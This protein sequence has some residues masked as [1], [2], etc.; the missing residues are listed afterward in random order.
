MLPADNTV[1]MERHALGT[2]NYIRASIESAGALAVP[3]AAGIAMGMV[4]AA[5]ALLAA[6]PALGAHWFEI[7]LLAAVA[8]LALGG[9]LMARQAARKGQTLYRGPARKF[10]LCLC[11]AL[12]AGAALTCV[13][14][15][16][17]VTRL[18]PGAW[19]LLY[20]CAVL[21]ASAMTGA[22]TMRLVGLM[23]GLFVA[24]GL[25]AFELPPRWHNLALGLGFGALHLTF[26]TLIAHT[27][28]DDQSSNHE[29]Q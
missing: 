25:V 1:A 19:L 5:A 22:N 18:V 26:G 10:L 28:H 13:L 12:I 8:A 17:G 11:P 3:G 29:T 15:Q 7:W 4:G 6:V 2:L 14:W 21:S 27:N 23:G 16:A 20:G 9:L 24:G